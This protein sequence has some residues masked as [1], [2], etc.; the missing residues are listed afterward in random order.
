MGQKLARYLVSHNSVTKIDTLEAVGQNS[1]DLIIVGK[2][3][4]RGQNRKEK[5]EKDIKNY[6]LQENYFLYGNYFLEGN[7]FLQ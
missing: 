7:Y 3:L 5:A 1:M 2:R 6:F 4:W